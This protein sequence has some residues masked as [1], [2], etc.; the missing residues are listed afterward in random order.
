MKQNLFSILFTSLLT[1]LIS[2][3]NSIREEN[4]QLQQDVSASIVRENIV[5]CQEDL[6]GVW[7]ENIEGNALFF[8]K[9]DSLWYVENQETPIQIKMENDTLRVFAPLPFYC[10]ILKLDR[11]SICYIDNIT[12]EITRLIKIK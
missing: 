10:K 3:N 5:F 6:Q 4:S 9:G 7:S 2:C 1:I 8:I 12:N 11:D